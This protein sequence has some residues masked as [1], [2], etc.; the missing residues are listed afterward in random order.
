MQSVGY[1][2]APGF[3]V[4][5]LAALSLAFIREASKASRRETRSTLAD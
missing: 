5:S 4:M 2:V 3:Q 1:V